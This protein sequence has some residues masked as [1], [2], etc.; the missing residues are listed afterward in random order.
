VSTSAE[1][2]TRNSELPLRQRLSWERELLGIYLSDHPV[3]DV[4]QRVGLAGRQQIN[5][6]EHRFPGDRVRIIGR[7]NTARRILTKTNK[8]MAVLDFEDM[9]GSIELVAFPETYT[10]FQDSWEVDNVIEIEAKVDRRGEQIQLICER[11]FDSIDMLGPKQSSR[12]VHI[13]IGDS[14]GDANARIDEMQRILAIVREHDG[15]DEVVV[16]L[17]IGED[18]FPMRSRTLKVEWND[19]LKTELELLL[20]LNAVW[21]EQIGEAA[22]IAA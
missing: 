20:G 5:D 8:T 3:N 21:I 6:V 14:G 9:T 13:V 19:L 17:R 1:L 18:D 7:I 10:T 16:H 12:Q 11:V 15:D 2:V 4:L 22:P